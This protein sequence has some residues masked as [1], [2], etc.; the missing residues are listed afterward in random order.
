MELALRFSAKSQQPGGG[1]DY[2]NVRTL[3]NDLSVTGWMVM[4]VHSARQGGITIDPTMRSSLRKYI[5]RAVQPSGWST[6]AD[7]GVGKG[8]QGISIAAVGML[9]KLYL[10]WSPRSPELRRT[11]ERILRRPPDR[12]SRVHWEREFQSSYYWYYATLALFHLGGDSWDAWNVLLQREVL[13]LQRTRGEQA[14]SWDPDPNWLGAEGGRIS[15]TA[16][17]I[18]SFEV[19]YRYRPLHEKYGLSR[20]N[21]E[22]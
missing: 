22:D 5:S 9:S 15:T 19:Y 11:A 4:A 2:T 14:G 7:R 1:W 12:D 18:L 6:Y 17:N 3:R 10:D 20:P 13:P 16:L 8:R 21:P